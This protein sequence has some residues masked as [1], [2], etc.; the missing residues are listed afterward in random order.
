MSSSVAVVKCVFAF[1]VCDPGSP[2][3]TPDCFEGFG[4]SLKGTKRD[5]EVVKLVMKWAGAEEPG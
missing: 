3:L 4:F 5:V 1:K 2:N